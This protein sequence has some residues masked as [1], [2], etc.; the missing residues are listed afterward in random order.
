MAWEVEFTDEFGQWWDG[1]SEAEQIDVSA[2]VALLEENGP[3]LRY[4]YSSGVK[5]SQHGQMRELRVQ[6]RGRPYRILYAFDPLRA[7]ILL[8][9]G[10]KTGNNHWY[11]EYVPVADRL[12]DEHLATL[13][14]EGKIPNE[15]IR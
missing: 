14:K 3:G 12:Y 6:H 13:K 2:V 1:L 11:E 5:G 4:P 10:D 9:G 7:A 15:K 8:L